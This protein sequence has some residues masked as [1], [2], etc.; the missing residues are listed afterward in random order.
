[1]DRRFKNKG[2]QEYIE[3]QFFRERDTREKRENSQ[4][5]SSE[6]QPHT[7]RDSQPSCQYRDNTCTK[8]YDQ[9]PIQFE[10]KF[11]FPL[12]LGYIND[13][14]TFRGLSIN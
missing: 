10:E 12:L 9:E 1:M 6:H 5:N 2:W 7:I 8:Q 4:T 3:N 14:L 13:F 11:H